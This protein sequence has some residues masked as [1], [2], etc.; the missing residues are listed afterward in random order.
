MIEVSFSQFKN[1][2]ASLKVLPPYD[3]VPLEYPNIVTLFGM[4]I[5][6]NS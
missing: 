2:P 4:I 6:S 3:I 5:D 1:T